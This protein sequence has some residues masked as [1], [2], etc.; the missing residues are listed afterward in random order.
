MPR[1]AGLVVELG[2]VVVGPWVHASCP[3]RWRRLA[4]LLA[5]SL[6]S[7]QQQAVDVLSRF[8]SRRLPF[9]AAL[10]KLPAS[11]SSRGLAGM[12]GVVP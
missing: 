9:P 6:Q 12:G 2:R 11:Q 1:L 8:T 10:A 5:L 4:F 3:H 7:L